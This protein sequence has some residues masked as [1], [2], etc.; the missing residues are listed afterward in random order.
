MD[1]SQGYVSEIALKGNLYRASVPPVSSP[2]VEE[3]RTLSSCEACRR[4]SP[5]DIS[6]DEFLCAGE[7]RTGRR[8]TR[9][10]TRASRLQRTL[11]MDTCENDHC[12][13]GAAGAG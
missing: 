8:K 6:D 9:K 11:H 7:A 10:G 2:K 5:A 3:R 12:R 4:S 1:L 13:S